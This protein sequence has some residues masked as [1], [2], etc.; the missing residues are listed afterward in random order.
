M[1]T[2]S[3]I[4]ATFYGASHISYIIAKEGELPVV[5]EKKI[6]NRPIE[7]LVIISGITLLVVNL[8]DLSSIATMG[9][10]G[11][12]LI[13]AAVNA[14]NLRLYRKTASY[15]WIS[16]FG[17]VVCVIALGA[18]VRLT[19]TISPQ[20]LCVLATMI[21]LAFTIEAIYRKFTGR[22]IRPLFKSEL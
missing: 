10:A 22:V 15:R 6:W 5:L 2:S 3:A 18:L 14:C 11:F 4:N 17:V 13:F 12:L 21:G 16:A 9:S 7:G 19:A 20:D 1:S 8:F